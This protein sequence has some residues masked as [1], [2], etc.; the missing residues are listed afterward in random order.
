MTNPNTAKWIVDYFQ[1]TGKMLEPC[2]GEG[3]FYTAMQEYNDDVDWCE[4]SEGKDFFDYNG[5]FCLKFKF[6]FLLFP[7]YFRKN[8]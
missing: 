6:L 8:L 2:R 7:N 4:I 3:A 1:P 5:I